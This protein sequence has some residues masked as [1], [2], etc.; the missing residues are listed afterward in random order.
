MKFQEAL[1]NYLS[2][3][4]DVLENDYKW[5]FNTNHFPFEYNKKSSSDYKNNIDLR[6][7]ISKQLQSNTDKLS[8]L[9]V[10]YVK[11]WGGVKSNNKTTLDNYIN[12]TPEDLISNGSK[13]IASWSKI[14]SIREPNKYVIYDAR[15]ALSLNTISLILSNDSSLFFPQLSSRNTK[16]I[17]AQNVISDKVK[18]LKLKYDNRFYSNYLAHLN[19]A[20]IEC[21]NKFDIQTAEMIL[22]ANAEKFAKIWTG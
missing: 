10:W 21:D 22:F 9:Q 14:L 12:S 11:H 17:A 6:L 5:S 8:E 16:I 7:F 4:I 2:L 3:N 18:L 20:V 13:G 1:N 19:K 15:V